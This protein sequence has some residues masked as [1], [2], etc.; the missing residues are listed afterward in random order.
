MITFL[1]LATGLLFGHYG[2]DDAAV[3][4][5]L[6]VIGKAPEFELI[7]QD[8]VPFRSTELSGKVVLVSFVFTTCNGTCPAT[9]HRMCQIQDALKQRGLLKDHRVRLLSITLDPARDTPEVLRGYMRLYDA[10]A[11]SWTFL[12][13]TKEVVNKVVKDWRMWAKPAAN[14][15]L[16]HPSRIYLVDSRG[17]IREIYNLGFMKTDWVAEDIA[18]LLK[19]IGVSPS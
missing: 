8:G 16:D 3:A 6:A 19:E 12:T 11:A 7:T 1:Y 15:Q 13:G 4:S 9:T 17:R 10:D 2:T 18:I 5:R 14:G